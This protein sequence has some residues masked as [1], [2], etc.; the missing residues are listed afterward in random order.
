MSKREFDWIRTCVKCGFFTYGHATDGPCP[1]CGHYDI[2]TVRTWSLDIGRIVWEKA[3]DNC[4]WKPW[5]WDRGY[6]KIIHRGYDNH[7]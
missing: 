1:K 7:G 3:P 2:V 5:T 6:Y 4:W